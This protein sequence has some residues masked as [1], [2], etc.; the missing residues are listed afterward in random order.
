MRFRS[1]RQKR[2]QGLVSPMKANYRV[3]LVTII[4]SKLSIINRR[5]ADSD[6]SAASEN[7][8]VVA[9]FPAAKDESFSPKIDF[10]S[11]SDSAGG[12]KNSKQ[13]KMKGL[14]LRS[15]REK[16]PSSLPLPFFLFFHA[17]RHTDQSWGMKSNF[18]IAM[19]LRVNLNYQSKEPII[20]FYTN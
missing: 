10:S 1:W 11:R 14:G 19:A 8:T 12:A 2:K 16:K 7:K 17:L 6:P 18:A 9:L 20:C 4:W 3:V 13:E 15:G 5:A